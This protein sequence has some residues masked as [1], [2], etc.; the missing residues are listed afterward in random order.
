MGKSSLLNRF[1]DKAACSGLLSRSRQFVLGATKK[2]S[3]GADYPAGQQHDND[4][5][6]GG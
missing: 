6:Q 5:E 4:D 1:R 2:R 3:H